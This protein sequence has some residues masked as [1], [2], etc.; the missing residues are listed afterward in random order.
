MGG[1]LHFTLTAANADVKTIITKNVI[2]QKRMVLMYVA[3]GFSFGDSKK[4]RIYLKNG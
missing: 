1:G 4:E 2:F 3:C